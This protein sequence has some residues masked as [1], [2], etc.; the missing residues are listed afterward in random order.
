M[1]RYCTHAGGAGR[2]P[3]LLRVKACCVQSRFV[4]IFG[5]GSVAHCYN[6]CI[7]L[8]TRTNEWSQPQTTGTAPSPRA[9]AR[10]RCH[11]PA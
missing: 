4:V 3:V 6:D 5:G 1:I 10:Q 2:L 11:C 9:G 7:L 8:D